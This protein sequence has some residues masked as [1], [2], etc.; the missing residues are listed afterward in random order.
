M[1]TSKYWWEVIGEEG[2]YVRLRHKGHYIRVHIHKLILHYNIK[3]GYMG[4]IYRYNNETVMVLCDS[5]EADEGIILPNPEAVINNA[6]DRWRK[7]M[8][9]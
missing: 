8:G 7:L 1:Y 3:L 5:A 9:R 4:H 6:W 2:E